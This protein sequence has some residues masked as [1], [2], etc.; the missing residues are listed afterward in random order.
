MLRVKDIVNVEI[1]RETTSK[2]V[3]N[4][5][6]IAILSV[7]EN[8]TEA[9][10]K[11]R[12]AAE[13]L[14]DGF[15]S[16][17]FA[18]IAAQRIFSQNPTVL[19]IVVGKAEGDDYV[20]DIVNLEKATEDWFFL[21]TDAES[22]ADKLAIAEYIETRT[23]FY[24]Y[25]DSNPATITS[26]E[27]CLPFQLK[28]RGLLKSAFLYTKKTDLVAP[29]AAWAGR[30]AADSLGSNVWVYKTLVGLEAEGYSATELANL[31]AKN[32]QYYTKVGQDPV[33]AGKEV[34][35]GGEHIHVI[36]GCI[37]LE[38]RIAERYWSLL[39][40][41]NR[42]LYTQYGVDLFKAELVS[43]LNEAADNNILTRDEDFEIIVP[44]VNALTPEQ[45]ASGVLNGIKFTARLA[46]A[47]LFVNKVQGV[48]YP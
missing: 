35:A 47:I 12:S 23:A 16:T 48:V 30:F 37:W 44:N 25:S 40:R 7:H 34:V 6:T 3:R 13:L 26:S 19:E 45:R 38:V 4:L 24:I 27:N 41:K 9:F 28:E 20:A 5:Q 17:D 39:F 11:Y 32:G 8:F 29:E 42:I 15:S 31:N 10:R 33:V 22:D 46:G 2:T 36:L 43:V 18:Y 14:A 21:I 1:S